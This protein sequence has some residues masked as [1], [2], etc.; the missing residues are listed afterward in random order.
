MQTSDNERFLKLWF[1]VNRYKIGFGYTHA[2]AI[3]SDYKWFPYNKGIGFRKWYGNN[4]YVVNFY[5][6]GEELKYWLVHNPKDPGTKHWSRNMRNYDYYFENGIT[7]T[8]IGNGFSA[9]LNGEG[10]LFDTKGPTMFG[11]ELIIICGFVNSVVFDYYNRMLCKQITKSADSVNLVPFIL[12]EGK[13]YNEIKSDVELAVALSKKDWDSYESSWDFI[14]HPLVN[15]DNSIKKA[16]QQWVV[17]LQERSRKLKET[18]ERIN[19]SF[20]MIYG[21]Q[22]EL[23]EIKDSSFTIIRKPDKTSDIKSLI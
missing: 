14:K 13:I 2:D 16:F 1:E 20:I 8:A 21:L 6:D 5:H 12:P 22:K 19:R 18:E 10:Y 23:A 3:K 17:L 7:F 4:D 9:R 11:R 15:G